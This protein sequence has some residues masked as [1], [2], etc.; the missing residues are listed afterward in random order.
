MAGSAGL[1]AG[2]NRQ[3][4]AGEV[5][6]PLQ[7]QYHGL[8]EY[9]RFLKRVVKGKPK[10]CWKWTGSRVGSW[11]GQWRN[12]AG[13]NELTHRAA[14]RLMKG[15]IPEGLFVLHRCDNPVCVNPAHLF[16]GTQSDNLKDMWAKGRARPKSNL[17]EKHGMSKL[18]TEQVLTIRA[19]RES[20]KVLAR[21]FH[22]APTTIYD[23]LKRKIWKHV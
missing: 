17:G 5:I 12:G 11:H 6:R 15:E 2:H 19:S 22:V 14:W 23:V 16:L 20:A 10:D 13:L 4:W 21:Q 1:C 8:S 7:V 3:R 9:A 18:T